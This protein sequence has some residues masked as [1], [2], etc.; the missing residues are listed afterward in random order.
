MKFYSSIH[1]GKH[2]NYIFLSLGI[3]NR[4]LIQSLFADHPA[5]PHNTQDIETSMKALMKFKVKKLQPE[6]ICRNSVN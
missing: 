3:F 1:L 4:S 2:V 6:L 5:K